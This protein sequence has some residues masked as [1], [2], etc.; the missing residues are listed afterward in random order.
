LRKELGIDN[1]LGN[2]TYTPATPEARFWL[3]I[4]YMLIIWKEVLWSIWQTQQYIAF[5]K[6]TCVI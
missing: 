1:S 3:P 5:W 4:E 6:D 2:P